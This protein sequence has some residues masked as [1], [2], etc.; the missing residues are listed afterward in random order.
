MWLGYLSS[1]AIYILT[2]LYNLMR[3]S[4]GPL[5]H[6]ESS[7]NS[8]LLS[9]CWNQSATLPSYNGLYDSKCYESPK[10]EKVSH[11]FK[12]L[13]ANIKSYNKDKI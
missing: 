11:A 13:I 12:H 7:T 8:V 2:L 6:L 10:K 4:S 5:A 9:L 1:H 3:F